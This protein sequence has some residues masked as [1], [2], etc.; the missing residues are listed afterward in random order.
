V[1][2]RKALRGC[3]TL[4]EQRSRYGKPAR[5]GFGTFEALKGQK[6]Q[7]RQSSGFDDSLLISSTAA[8]DADSEGQV[9]PK[10]GS[11]GFVKNSCRGWSRKTL[12]VVQ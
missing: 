3:E 12:K 11:R 8:P 4:K 9:K 1:L 7:E 5:S 2:R 10:K 6:A